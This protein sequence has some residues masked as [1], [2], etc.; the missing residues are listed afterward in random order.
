MTDVISC[1]CVGDL[2]SVAPRWRESQIKMKFLN[3]TSSVM[4]RQQT[5]LFT[6]SNVL[7]WGAPSCLKAPFT[8]FAL[9]FSTAG[10]MSACLHRTRC[11]YWTSAPSPHFASCCLLD[12]KLWGCMDAVK[13]LFSFLFQRKH[14]G[15]VSGKGWGECASAG[16]GT[17]GRL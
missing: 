8:Y 7:N 17:D 1:P 6:A 5:A 13:T 9:I 3:W 2:V 12:I 10:K 4:Y 14:Y 16:R 11:E 15:G